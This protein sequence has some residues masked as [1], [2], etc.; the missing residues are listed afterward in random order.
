MIDVDRP[1]LFLLLSHLWL[2]VL[3]A[4]FVVAVTLVIDFWVLLLLVMASDGIEC[5]NKKSLPDGARTDLGCSWGLFWQPT[6]F[7][8]QLNSLSPPLGRLSRQAI[9]PAINFSLKLSR[10]FNH[11]PPNCPYQDDQMMPEFPMTL[12]SAVKNHAA[13]VL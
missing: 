9:S 6:V 5:N 7:V 1:A 8:E 10:L 12:I 13:A 4:A 2:L 11:N 3:V